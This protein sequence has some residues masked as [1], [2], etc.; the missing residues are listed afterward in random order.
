MVDEASKVARA[1]ENRVS[2]NDIDP[3]DQWS[4]LTPQGE[5]DTAAICS[6]GALAHSTGFEEE[7]SLN[8]TPKGNP[9]RC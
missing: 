8:I 2:A 3:E 7:V 6:D 5:N 1:P 4:R 9:N